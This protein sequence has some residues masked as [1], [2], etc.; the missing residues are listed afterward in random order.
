VLRRTFG[1]QQVRPYLTQSVSH[2]IT[3]AVGV[4][5]SMASLMMKG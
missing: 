1:G 3:E 4:F 5:V 2:L